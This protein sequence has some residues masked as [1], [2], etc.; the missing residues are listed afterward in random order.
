MGHFYEPVPNSTTAYYQDASDDE[1]YGK[2]S[3]GHT[4]AQAVWQIFK[5]EYTAGSG[6]NKDWIILYP[7]DTGTGKASDQT[8][9]VWDNVDT[10]DY[11]EL[12]T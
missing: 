9:F 6:S 1:Y 8:M 7:V 5:M 2:A 12:G 4:T 3:K 11:R 10:Y